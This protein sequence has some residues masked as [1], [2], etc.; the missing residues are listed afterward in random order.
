MSLDK[1]EEIIETFYS[2]GRKRISLLTNGYNIM[3]M[4]PKWLNKI[5]VINL[6]DHGINHEHIIKCYEYLKKAYK[7]KVQILEVLKH[8]NWDEARKHPRNIL[9][10]PCKAM[11]RSPSPYR[12]VIY[13]C[14][15]SMHTDGMR[16]DMKGIN[17]LRSV[18][19][20]FHNPNVAETLRNWRTTLPK[21]ILEK[22][23]ADCPRPYDD[24]C[25]GKLITLKDNDV[26]YSLENKEVI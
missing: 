21:Y 25:R 8:W 16:K 19:W 17:A 9:I 5:E 20:T 14:C 10:K 22:C 11:M 12:G 18:G 15:M 26:I 7:G 6:D 3:G 24:I 4:E 2:Y 1:L 23:L 13:P